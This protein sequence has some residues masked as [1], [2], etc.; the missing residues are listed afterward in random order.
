MFPKNSS[1]GS[2]HGPAHSCLSEHAIKAGLCVGLS[3]TSTDP[4]LKG[5]FASRVQWA[6]TAVAGLRCQLPAPF[7]G[8]IEMG[9]H[10]ASFVEPVDHTISGW[11][12]QGTSSALL[13]PVFCLCQTPPCVLSHVLLDGQ[14]KQ[15]ERV[16]P[17]MYI[18]VCGW[19]TNNNLLDPRP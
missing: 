8:F 4:S 14:S 12:A 10:T 16:M 5:P 9:G 6:G 1:S 11:T 7:Q 3:P 15:A 19:R 17:G 2:F 13:H 18:R